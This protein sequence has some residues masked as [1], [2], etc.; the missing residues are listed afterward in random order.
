MQNPFAGAGAPSYMGQT[1][2][3]PATANQT[4]QGGP[5][6]T[7]DYQQAAVDQQAAQQQQAMAANQQAALANPQK[8]SW[9]MRAWQTVSGAMPPWGWAVLLVG[10]VW[11]SHRVTAGKPVVPFRR[12]K[13]KGSARVTISTDD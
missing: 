3:N 8:A 1:P 9:P 6:L 12:S 11:V 7:A 13:K 5:T 10:G 2:I 4:A